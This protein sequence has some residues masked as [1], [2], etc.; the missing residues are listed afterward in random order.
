[1]RLGAFSSN[2]RVLFMEVL[3]ASHARDDV[4]ELRD[5]WRAL[6]ELS[7]SGAS[8]RPASL[9]VLDH[10]SLAVE[11]VEELGALK[12]GVGLSF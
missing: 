9:D 8:N 6:D 3:I 1:M 4:L 2:G 12:G 11:A 7:E 10:Q 5:R